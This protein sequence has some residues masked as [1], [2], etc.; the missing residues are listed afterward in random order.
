MRYQLALAMI[1]IYLREIADPTVPESALT[2]RCAFHLRLL[3]G[4][5][6]DYHDYIDC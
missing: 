3:W 4:D 1:R 2:P 6:N 5:Q